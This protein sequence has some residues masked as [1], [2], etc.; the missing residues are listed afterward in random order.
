MGM[1]FPD[2]RFTGILPLDN[3]QFKIC[4]KGEAMSLAPSLV[5]LGNNR[6]KPAVL[7][8]INLHK[9][10]RTLFSLTSVKQKL[11]VLLVYEWS[12]YHFHLF[13]MLQWY[14]KGFYIALTRSLRYNYACLVFL[15]LTRVHAVFVI[16]L[17][18]DHI[19]RFISIHASLQQ[20][21]KHTAD[22]Q[23]ANCADR[24]RANCADRQRAKC[25][26]RQRAKCAD[27]QRANC[28]DR[29]G[30]N[31]ADRQRANC[32]DRQRANCGDRQR[33]KCAVRQHAIR[34]D[35]LL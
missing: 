22:R 19:V 31:C 3:D 26:D 18:F 6:T 7:L 29:Q 16:C 2:L 25:A 17:Y 4:V 27:R 28:A 12:L 5:N 13:V 33:A 23:R 24:Q 14:M 1:T 21:Y 10:L 30:A 8:E 32:A 9:I 35:R 15:S 20:A 34:A 11:Y